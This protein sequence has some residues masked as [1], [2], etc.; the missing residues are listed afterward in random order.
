MESNGY[1]PQETLY[2]LDSGAGSLYP[3]DYAYYDPNVVTLGVPP[4][5]TVLPV[6]AGSGVYL[7][8]TVA[9]P[10]ETGGVM[11]TVGDWL[12]NIIQTVGA[13][14]PGLITG[15]PTS[16]YTTAYRA[17]TQ[18]A[19]GISPMMLLLLGGGA[20]LLF[21]G[22]RRGGGGARSNPRRR[23]RRRTYRSGR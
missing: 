15:Q 8:T 7:P 10:V 5:D 3:V 12:S 19:G 18:A 1:Y 23:Y 14:A 13:Q 11:A 9:Q 22:R 17:P 21:A 16:P 4:L 2:S 20:L 6:G